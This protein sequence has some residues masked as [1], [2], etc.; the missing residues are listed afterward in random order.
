MQTAHDL[1]I[2]PH[3]IPAMFSGLQL[4]EDGVAILFVKLRCLEA[5]GFQFGEFTTSPLRFGFSSFQHLATQSLAPQVFSK[6]ENF[7][8]QPAQCG[9]PLCTTHNLPVSVPHKYGNRVSSIPGLGDIKF[10]K[11]APK[12]LRVFRCGLIFNFDLIPV[13][14]SYGRESSD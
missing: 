8:M 3:E 14:S 9:P 13:H 4:R 7:D 2:L 6:P 11:T 5:E 12:D 1:Q 10:I